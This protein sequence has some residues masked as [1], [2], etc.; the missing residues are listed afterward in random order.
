MTSDHLFPLLESERDSIMFAEFAQSLA[1]ADVL[2]QV[3][4][5][6]GLGQLIALKKRDGGV[7]GIVVGD[8]LRRLVGKTMAKQAATSNT[9]CSQ[10][11]GTRVANLRP[12]CL[13][14]F[15]SNGALL[16]RVA[17]GCM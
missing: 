6:L 16:L 11:R 10:V 2:H 1:V 7:R 3:L 14:P 17:E 12:F 4:R 15:L 5:I 8:V 9:L 13:K